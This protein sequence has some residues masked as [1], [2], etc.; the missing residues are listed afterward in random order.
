MAADDDLEHY[1]HLAE[2]TKKKLLRGEEDNPIQTM[3][4]TYQLWWHWANLELSIDSPQIAPF[5]APELIYPEK[6]ADSDKTEPVYTIADYGNKLTTSKGDDMYVA[7]MSMF[8]L[9][10]TIEKMIF[11]LV[12]RLKAE[13]I[14][15]ETEVHISLQ[16]FEMAKRKA[17]ES[18]INLSYNVVV[19]NFNPDAWGERYLQVVKILAEKGYGYPPE[20]P[21]DKYRF[22]PK[23]TGP[24]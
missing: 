19:T 16:G 11:I 21:R 3:E 2:E 20:S 23:S 7:G 4:Q 6:Q 15:S 8:K 5:E 17:F 1:E 22:T 12:E 18:V 10:S 13:G 24:S 14:D 9:F